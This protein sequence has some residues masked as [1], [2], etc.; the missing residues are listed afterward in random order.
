MDFNRNHYLVVGVIV[1]LLGLQLRVVESY[2]LTDQVSKFLAARTSGSE[3]RSILPAAG[4]TAP[5][6]TISPPAWIGWCLL[7]VGSV[8][9][10]HSLAMKKPGG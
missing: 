5:R 4:P 1:F 9:V 3:G 7:S 6:K 2:T 10:L 8:L